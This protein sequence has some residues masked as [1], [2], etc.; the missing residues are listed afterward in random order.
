MNYSV[1]LSPS[2]CRE[3]LQGGV[4]GRVG[5]ATPVGP[6]IVPVNYQVHE[7]AIVFRTAPYSELSRYGW[8]TDLA[9]EVDDYDRETQAAW[10]VVAVGRAHVVD[11]PEE[12]RRLQQPQALQSWASGSR[13]LFVKLSWRDLTGV[14]LGDAFASRAPTPRR[15]H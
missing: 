6:R 9:F 12:V 8:D 1:A 13:H 4:V 15:G 3:L 2:E 5:M 10:S 14:R 7:N 11:D